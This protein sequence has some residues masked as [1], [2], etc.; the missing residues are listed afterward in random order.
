[1]NNYI[2]QCAYFHRNITQTQIY[3]P[4]IFPTVATFLLSGE[5]GEIAACNIRKEKKR[6]RRVAS[7]DAA[8]RKIANILRHRRH[9]K[10]D[11]ASNWRLVCIYSGARCPPSCPPTCFLCYRLILKAPKFTNDKRRQCRSRARS[12][13][14]I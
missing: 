8:G 12:D 7:S 6:K 1:M 11:G 3:S 9:C 5:T 2:V 4:N 14:S 10:R 13:I